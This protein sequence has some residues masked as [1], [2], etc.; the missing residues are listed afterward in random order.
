MGRFGVRHCDYIRLKRMI[1]TFVLYYN[2][3]TF[4]SATIIRL[5]LLNITTNTWYVPYSNPTR[6]KTHLKIVYR[7]GYIIKEWETG[8]E[9]MSA[10]Q[11]WRVDMP[12]KVYRFL[13]CAHVPFHR[14]RMA[15]RMWAPSKMIFPYMVW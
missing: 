4:T 6:H 10:E 7:R 1:F 9:W 14:C 12:N 2:C 5:E 3:F 15:N 8:A 13:L 11:D